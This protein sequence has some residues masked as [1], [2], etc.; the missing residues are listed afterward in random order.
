MSPSA[1]LCVALLATAPSAAPELDAY[2][3]L[4][5][6]P[7]AAQ[8]LAAAREG[9]AE[10]P[11]GAWTSAEWPDAPRPVY[12]TLVHGHT[13]RA[14]VGSDAPLGSLAETVRA[15]AR[16]VMDSDRRRAPVRAEELDSLSVRVAFAGDGE[17]VAD[18]F[19]LDPSREGLRIET[20]RGAVAFLPGEARTVRWALAEARRIGVLHGA[21]SEARCTRFPVVVIQGAAVPAPPRPTQEPHP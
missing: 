7:R 8:V 18:P 14:C 3:A 4:A 13:T 21:W 15:L 19:T 12:V 5:R 17:S 2:R 1:L 11:A 6:S 16:R 20:E 9:L 10:V